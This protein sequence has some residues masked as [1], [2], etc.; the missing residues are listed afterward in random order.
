MPQNNLQTDDS[1]SFERNLAGKYLTFQLGDENYGC[2]IG[3]I[4]D[5][6]EMQETTSVPQTRDYVEGVINLRGTVI[7]VINLRQK[8]NMPFKEHDRETVI[9]VVDLDGLKTGLIVDKVAEVTEVSDNQ[10]QDAPSMGQ[11]IDS[12]FIAG[13]GKLDERVLILL[14]LE[15]VLK[16]EEL[17]ELKSMKDRPA[18]EQ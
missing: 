11:E 9:I 17:E 18:A 14:D 6:I 7:P 8:F 16:E 3:P 1:R 10:V 13:M 15:H 5:I 2:P 12:R 4:D